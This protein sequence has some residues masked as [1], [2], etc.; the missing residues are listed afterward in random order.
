MKVKSLQSCPTLSDPMDCSPPGSSI[1]GI[2][3]MQLLDRKTRAFKI[4]MHIAKLSPNEVAPVCSPPARSVSAC[5][6]LRLGDEPVYNAVLELS[7]PELNPLFLCDPMTSV[8]IKHP[9]SC[10]LLYLSLKKKQQKNFNTKAA[11][12]TRATSMTFSH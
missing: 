9:L 8:N 2:R 1:H 4:L 12:V 5:C 6:L 10:E 7:F 3:A 11:I